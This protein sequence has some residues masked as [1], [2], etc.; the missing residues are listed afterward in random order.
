MIFRCRNCGETTSD[1]DMVLEGACKCGGTKFE[2]VS[3]DP[4]GV[5]TEISPRERIR[6][7]LH[8]WV[9]LNIDSLDVNAINNLRVRFEFDDPTSH[10]ISR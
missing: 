3:E 1:I 9:D 10:A 7:D 4:L 8:L 2:L 6:R 5:S